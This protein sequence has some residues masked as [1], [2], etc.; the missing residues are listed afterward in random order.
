MTDYF[1]RFVSTLDPNGAGAVRW[2]RFNT[3]VRATLQF[4]DGKVPVNVTRDSARLAG[5]DAVTNLRMKFPF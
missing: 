4:N 1:V 3:S 5:T 2:P